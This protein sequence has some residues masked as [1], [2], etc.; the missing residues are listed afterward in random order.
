MST[1]PNGAGPKKVAVVALETVEISDDSDDDF[2]YAAVDLP[3]DDDDIGSDDDDA[4]VGMRSAAQPRSLGS[5]Q[6]TAAGGGG[7]KKEAA[8]ATSHPTT[9]DDFIRNFLLNSGLH[10]ALDAF[11]TEWY[12]AKAMGLIKEGDLNVVPD[13][14]ARNA[15]LEEEV[16][17]LRDDLQRQQAVAAK[18]QATWDKFRKE[19]DFHKMHHQRVVQEKNRLVTDI[20]RLKKQYE[21]YEPTMKEMRVKYELAMKE[22]VLM[23]LEKDKVAVRCASLEAQVCVC[24]CGCVCV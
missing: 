11:N 22:K 14:Y 6:S 18:A 13:I 5:T 9:I 10:R 1:D 4:L 23:R 15:E 16:I 2:E 17:R 21:A 3:S 19:R 24:V 12:E 7:R 20:K 8:D